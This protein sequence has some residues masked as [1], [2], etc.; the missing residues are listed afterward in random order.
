[1]LK[2][3]FECDQRPTCFQHLG[4]G[5]PP[6][7]TL[8]S[9]PAQRH[10]ISGEN[11]GK[12]TKN[13]QNRLK[14][15]SNENRLKALKSDRFN[16]TLT[17]QN[18]AFLSSKTPPAAGRQRNFGQTYQHFTNISAQ[19]FNSQHQHFGRAVSTLCGSL[20][21][22]SAV[23]GA[24]GLRHA[25]RRACGR[26]GASRQPRR[27]SECR[28]HTCRVRCGL[29]GAVASGRPRVDPRVARATV[30]ASARTMSKD[31]TRGN[32]YD[33]RETSM[34]ARRSRLPP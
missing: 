2:Q 30:R 18:A 6:P 15:V 12:T 26:A 20:I 34:Q 13:A 28:S 27:V 3:H 22:T 19:S 5:E 8:T 23:S 4:G 24:R 29:C 25:A 11:R 9:D 14:I 17:P 10:P 21:S 33:K 16:I 1:M 31:W 32:A 7:V